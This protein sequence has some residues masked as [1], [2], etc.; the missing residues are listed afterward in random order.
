MDDI[1][2]KR[3][4]ASADKLMEAHDDLVDLLPAK[5]KKASEEEALLGDAMDS[6]EEAISCLTELLEEEV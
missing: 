2:K 4:Q 3:L 6:L 5:K 1:R